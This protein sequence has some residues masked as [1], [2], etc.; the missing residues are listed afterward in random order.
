VVFRVGV[1]RRLLLNEL[2]M[3]LLVRED[4]HPQ[5]FD[6]YACTLQSLS[7][8]GDPE[9][10]AVLRAFELL[11]LRETG[12]LPQLDRITATQTPVAA[13][14]WIALRPEQTWCRPRSPRA[15][16]TVPMPG[17]VGAL[18]ALA[19]TCRH[20]PWLGCRLPVRMRVQR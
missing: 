20:R 11:L 18:D 2:L 7:T 8:G 4:P 16:C 17:A 1:V 14:Q 3:R 9:P 19:T 13:D 10:Q 12:V 6:A 15:R 5:L